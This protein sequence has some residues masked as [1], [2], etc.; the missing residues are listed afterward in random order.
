MSSCSLYEICI[1]FFLPRTDA[2]GQLDAFL[3]NCLS[4]ESITF[5]LPRIRAALDGCGASS[6]KIGAYGNGFKT[7]KSDGKG[8]DYD[9]KLTPAAYG[10]V[11]IE[12]WVG[13]SGASIVGG[14][15]GIFPEHIEELSKLAKAL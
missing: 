14:C 2:G 13:K 9:E 12:E 10:E 3:I 1:F 11:A 4:L 6:V 15:C 7:A 8:P 5:A